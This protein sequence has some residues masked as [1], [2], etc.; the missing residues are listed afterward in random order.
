MYVL[1]VW[2]REKIIVQAKLSKDQKKLVLAY[3]DLAIWFEKVD[4]AFHQPSKNVC[5]VYIYRNWVGDSPPTEQFNGPDQLIGR[6]WV[7]PDGWHVAVLF[8]NK[9]LTT[10]LTLLYITMM[11]ANIHV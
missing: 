7:G 3:L 6:R 5:C 9:S 1:W 10:W 2:A 8:P 4:C 11:F